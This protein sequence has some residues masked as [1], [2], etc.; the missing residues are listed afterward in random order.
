VIDG[1]ID[2]ELVVVLGDSWVLKGWFE[3]RLLGA[4]AG[5]WIE[6]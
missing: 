1:V 4:I 2:G 5:L 3:V 6:L